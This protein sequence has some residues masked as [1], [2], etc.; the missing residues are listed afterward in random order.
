MKKILLGVL[1]S[2][3]LA[4]CH[5]EFSS[6]YVEPNIE[7]FIL[8]EKYQV[9]VKEG[10]VTNVMLG[11]DTIFV[12]NVSVAIDIPKYKTTSRSSGT[13]TTYT[14][15]NGN[16]KFYHATAEGTLI[17]EDLDNGDNDYNDFVCHI[18]NT[19]RANIKPNSIF[20]QN[21]KFESFDVTPKALGNIL[22][23]AFGYEIVRTDLNEIIADVLIFEDIR[24]E[25]F[26]GKEGFINT[27]TDKEF[28]E[29]KLFHNKFDHRAYT[30]DNLHTDHIHV[31]YF[32]KVGDK[33][34]YSAN[35][36]N[37][38]LTLNN[39]PYGLFIPNT[40]SFLYP[41]EKVTITQAYPNFEAWSKGAQTNP[42]QEVR[43]EFLYVIK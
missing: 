12:G 20:V 28:V 11:E 26:G 31:N 7:N 4:S 17:F 19:M 34:R 24:Q 27:E 3:S 39:T 1:A 10:F 16:D 21:M 23:I 43:E 5:K 42:F 8:T 40:N 33:K 41:Q 35:T 36:H 37:Q 38:Q 2:V 9:P 30:P 29:T 14:P 13:I 25:A 32:I 22:P 6:L 18:K 15:D